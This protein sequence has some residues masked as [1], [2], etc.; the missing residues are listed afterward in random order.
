MSSGTR[1]FRYQAP[2][3]LRRIA[4]RTCVSR[5]CVLQVDASIVLISEEVAAN[6]GFARRAGVPEGTE[7]L[8]AKLPK[9]TAF[10]A[11][12]HAA[13]TAKLPAKSQSR[14]WP[15]STPPGA[16]SRGRRAVTRRVTCRAANS[17]GAPVPL[18]GAR[19]LQPSPSFRRKPIRSIPAPLGACALVPYRKW[20]GDGQCDCASVVRSR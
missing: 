13:K 12:C 4:S 18:E 3:L 5:A 2:R 15:L 7:H 8:A 1:K 19:R 9:N 6:Q 17:A 16:S 20:P 14:R 10:M 11:G